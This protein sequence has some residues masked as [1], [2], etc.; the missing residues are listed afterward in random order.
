MKAMSI[1]LWICRESFSGEDL[2]ITDVPEQGAEEWEQNEGWWQHQIGA[3]PERMAPAGKYLTIHE[4]RYFDNADSYMYDDDYKRVEP[5]VT[6]T[7]EDDGKHVWLYRID[8]GLSLSD[9]ERTS[10]K[11]VLHATYKTFRRYSGMN[12]G[13]SEIHNLYRED[14]DNII[15]IHDRL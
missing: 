1:L 13:R 5:D 8:E 4:G 12:I 11:G 9:S 15:N 3:V 14:I 6:L 2:I 7:F 10:L